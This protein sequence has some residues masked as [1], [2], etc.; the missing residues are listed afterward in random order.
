MAFGPWAKVFSLTQ[1]ESFPDTDR[2]SF[3]PDTDRT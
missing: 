2:N 1:T 3:F